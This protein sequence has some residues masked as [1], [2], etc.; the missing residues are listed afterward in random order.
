MV[1]LMAVKIEVPLPPPGSIMSRDYTDLATTTLTKVR[2][3]EAAM[4]KEGYVLGNAYTFRS[5][6]EQE[7]L[8]NQGR[9]TPGA[10]VTK[11]RKGWHNLTKN[12][13]PAARAIDWYF[14]PNKNFRGATGKKWGAFDDRWP[15]ELLHF[16]AKEHGLVRPLKWDKGHMVDTQEQSFS[17]AWSQRS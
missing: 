10:I 4:R 1:G 6:E 7:K 11:T 9:T 12:G 5:E 15:W 8:Y 13:E 16:I 2:A 14:T 17:E 3:V